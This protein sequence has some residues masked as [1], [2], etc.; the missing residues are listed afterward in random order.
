MLGGDPADLTALSQRLSATAESVAD[1]AAATGDAPFWEGVA[2]V[3][4]KER[5]AAIVTDLHALRADVDAAASTVADL[6]STVQERQQFL[7]NAWAEAREA[8]DNTV[9]AGVDCA[10]Q[11]WA[12]AEDA[13]GWAKDRLEDVK[14]W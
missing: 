14:F 12:Y 1:V 3:A 8:F 2:A 7:L 5:L 13:G 10:R 6:A 11:A 9:D 4:H